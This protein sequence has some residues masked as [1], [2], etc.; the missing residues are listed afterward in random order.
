V[1]FLGVDPGKKGA[2]CSMNERGQ[3]LE[4]VPTPMQPGGKDYDLEAIAQFLR[5]RTDVRRSDRGMFVTVERLQAMPMRFAKKGGRATDEDANV[6]GVLANF[7]RGVSHG[8]VWMLFAFRIPFAH[9]SPQTWQRTMLAGMPGATTKEKSIRAAKKAWPGL[10]LRR[11]LRSK[12]DDDGFADAVW[13]AEHGRR[14]KL[15]GA[16]FASAS[17]ATVE[18][19]P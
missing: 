10:D 12:T 1:I 4:L 11:T 16:V 13:L 7:N 17:R 5:A 14:T 15:G 18:S 2:L 19:R 8:W 9:V 3:I 6:G